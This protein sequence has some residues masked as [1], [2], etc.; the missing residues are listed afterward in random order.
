M[1]ISPAFNP[2]K[3]KEMFRCTPGHGAYDD[4]INGGKLCRYQKFCY[5]KQQ[6]RRKK[7]KF[8]KIYNEKF[9]FIIDLIER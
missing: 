7:N 3:C 4:Y 1:I 9:K 8:S 2:D 6:Q 5:E